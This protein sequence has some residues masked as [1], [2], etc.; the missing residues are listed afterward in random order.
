MKNA[1]NK[2][3]GFF[4]KVFGGNKKK[5]VTLFKPEKNRDPLDAKPVHDMFKPDRDPG[6]AVMQG[7]RKYANKGV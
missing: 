3:T 1:W 4:G 2:V 7:Q 5:G 6:K